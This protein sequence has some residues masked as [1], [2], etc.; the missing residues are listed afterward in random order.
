VLAADVAAGKISV[1]DA[2]RQVREEETRAKTIGEGEKPSQRTSI[3]VTHDGRERAYQLPKGPVKFNQQTNDQIS[4]AA[5]SWNP[6]TGCL[7]NCPYCYAREGAL[8][9]KNLKPFYPFGFDPTFYD[10]RL[11]APANS[12]VPEEA[13]NDPRLGRVFVTSMGDLFG[14]WRT[15][16]EG[17]GRMVRRTVET[18]RTEARRARSANSL[19]S[20]FAGSTDPAPR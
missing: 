17:D 1:S 2:Y 15:G 3:V 16:P 10:F 4:W 7:H 8:M 9:N 12:K 14:G 19:P 20:C 18:L 6:V 5:F 13:K 11:E